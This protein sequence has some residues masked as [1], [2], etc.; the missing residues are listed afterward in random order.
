VAELIG[1]NAFRD[2]DIRFIGAGAVVNRDV[3]PY[4]LI[5]GNPARQIGWMSAHGERLRFN[6]QGRAT[7]PGSGLLYQLINGAVVPTVV[8]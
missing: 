1:V 5:V 3:L 2:L 6:E 7:C 8:E 4:A